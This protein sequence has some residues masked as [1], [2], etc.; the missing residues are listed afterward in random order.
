MIDPTKPRRSSFTILNCVA[1]NMKLLGPS[2]KRRAISFGTSFS[3]QGGA[4]NNRPM[5]S[6]ED[7]PYT[8]MIFYGGW[9]RYEDFGDIVCGPWYFFS[10]GSVGTVI[11]LEAI[12]I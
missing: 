8:D 6:V 5:T 3:S 4:F 1:G 12:E 10:Q 11:A 2:E 7:G 9:L